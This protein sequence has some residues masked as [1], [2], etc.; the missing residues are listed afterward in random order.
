MDTQRVLVIEDDPD[1]AANL[2][3]ILELDDYRVELAG[4]LGEALE[5]EKGDELAAILVDRR[6]P[7]GNADD[8]LPEIRALGPDSSILIITGNA[9]LDGAVAALRQGA[10]D[11][12]LK[13]IDPTGA[14]GEHAAIPRHP[15]RFARRDHHHRRGGHHRVRQ[16]RR[17]TDLRLP[18]GRVD[19]PGHQHPHALVDSRGAR[20]LHPGVPEDGR[21]GGCSR[22][23]FAT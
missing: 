21:R 23:R 14:A 19:R 12:L 6:L 1:T 18:G 3:D 16:P 10:D 22:P 8:H 5:R 4:T 7:D 11:Y 13:P 17:G 20:P 9:D 2:R 15:G